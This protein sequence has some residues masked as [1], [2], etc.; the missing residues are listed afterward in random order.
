[1]RARKLENLTVPDVL[2]IENVNDGLRDGESYTDEELDALVPFMLVDWKDVN[3]GTNS[4]DAAEQYFANNF[5]SILSSMTAHLGAMIRVSYGTQSFKMTVTSPASSNGDASI[6]IND[7]SY[8][9]S[10]TT[11][12]SKADIAALFAAYNYEGFSVNYTE[13]NEYFDLINNGTA[14]D[15]S[16]VVFN[17]GNTGSAITISEST[18]YSFIGYC[19]Y[20]DDLT[21]WSDITK[22]ILTEELPL[23]AQYKGLIKYLSETFPDMWLFW[24]LANRYDNNFTINKNKILRQALPIWGIPLM[25]MERKASMNIWNYRNFCPVGIHT[26]Q[27]DKGAL[28]WAEA[29]VRCLF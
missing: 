29:M 25:D 15:S 21:R 2:V 18:S 8:V 7:T 22:W 24:M 1:M 26:N 14:V 23:M 28:R 10:L 17:A 12:M 20:S 27:Y 9:V 16:A 5:S 6:S 4:K 13:G 3:S 11:T 19:Y